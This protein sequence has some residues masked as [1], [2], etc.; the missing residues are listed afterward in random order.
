MEW[1]ADPVVR[2]TRAAYGKRGDGQDGE[3]GNGQ[4]D[5]GKSGC[6]HG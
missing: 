1:I 5:L 3:D 2:H 4:A 6:V